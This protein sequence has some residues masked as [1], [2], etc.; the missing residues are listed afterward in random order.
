[1]AQPQNRSGVR[2][3]GLTLQGAGGGEL[4]DPVASSHRRGVCLFLSQA[5]SR[6]LLPLRLLDLRLPLLLPPPPACYT[7]VPGYAFTSYMIMN[8]TPPLQV[9]KRLVVA[10][11]HYIIKVVDKDGI[12]TIKTV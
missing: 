5:P 4:S 11:P 10:P 8:V 1:M 2:R 9:K 12:R 3:R 7:T 6:L